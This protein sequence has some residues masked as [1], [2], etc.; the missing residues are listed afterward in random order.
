[1]Q[2]GNSDVIVDEDGVGG[3]VV[4]FLKFKGFVNNSKPLP[5]PNG[6]VDDKGNFILENFDNLKSQ[7]YFR[8]AD[9]INKGGVYLECESEEVKQWIIEELEQVKQ[10]VLDSDL[11]KGVVPKDKVKE[12]IGRSPDF[13]DTIMMREYFELKPK[14]ILAWA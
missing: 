1:M 9:R 2:I 14:K 11:K 7:C 4:D 12:M 10:K 13:S 5:A 6:P 8:L 3:G